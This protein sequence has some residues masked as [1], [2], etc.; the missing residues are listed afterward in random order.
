MLG[1]GA[2]LQIRLRL[3]QEMGAC[4]ALESLQ[5]RVFCVRR[6]RKLSSVK[7]QSCTRP[8]NGRDTS[9]FGV[10]HSAKDSSLGLECFHDTGELTPIANGFGGHGVRVGMAPL[11]WAPVRYFSSRGGLAGNGGNPSSFRKALTSDSM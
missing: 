1:K 5:H 6:V 8:A 4:L 10:G 11:S 7:I 9:V 2:P 3:E